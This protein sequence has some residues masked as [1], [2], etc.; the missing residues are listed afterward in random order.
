MYVQVL[1]GQKKLE[2][3]QD[4]F[5]EVL[6]DLQAKVA[7]QSTPSS[8]SPDFSNGKKRKRVVTRALSV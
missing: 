1:E 8:S 2:Q 5:E 6:L 4:K 7:R 3:R